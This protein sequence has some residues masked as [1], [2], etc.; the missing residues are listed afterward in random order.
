MKSFIHH[1]LQATTKEKQKMAKI[2]TKRKGN[3]KERKLSMSKGTKDSTW[4][5]HHAL[6][7]LIGKYSLLE[8]AILE[9]IFG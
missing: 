6:T 9:S 8:P 1:N 2:N 5:N 7:K 4:E 3:S